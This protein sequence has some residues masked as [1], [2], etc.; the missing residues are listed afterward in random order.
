[1]V[2]Q[3]TIPQDPKRFSVPCLGLPFTT[4]CLLKH[5]THNLHWPIL[6]DEP[7]T[8]TPMVAAGVLVRVRKA[9][10]MIS[11]PNL[12]CAH[13]AHILTPTSEGAQLGLLASFV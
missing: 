9:L 1:M 13:S 8:Q 11:T 3:G 12:R 10:T 6:C 4:E 2:P 5:A 7:E